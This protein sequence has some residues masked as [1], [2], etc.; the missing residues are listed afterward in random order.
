MEKTED[1]LGM[2][3]LFRRYEKLV[4]Q[5][6]GVK[7]ELR[8]AANPDDVLEKPAFYRLMQGRLVQDKDKKGWQRIAFF[9]P[10]VLGHKPGAEPLGRQLA[11]AKI[12]EM[13]LFQVL[14]SDSP[15][16]LI[17]LRRLVQQIEPRLNWI[18]FGE[19]LFYWNKAKKQQIVQ[20]FFIASASEEKTKPQG[21]PQ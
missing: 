5:N 12:S 4:D 21:S 16:D 1:A 10:Y 14:R 6:S 18:A 15:N 9:L 7:A 13:R 3:E 8:R 19:T 2:A 11:H 17:Q 20:D